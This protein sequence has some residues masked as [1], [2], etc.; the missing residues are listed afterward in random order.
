MM[1]RVLMRDI[2]TQEQLAEALEH[3]KGFVFGSK[4]YLHKTYGLHVS[5]ATI[6]SLVRKY[7]AL[8]ELVK[9]ERNSLL[10]T[11]MRKSRVIL[12]H[13]LD[14]LDSTGNHV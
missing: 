14:H 11:C 7:P 12:V 5:S 1:D 2:P 6:L 13:N 8:E 9:G 10:E 3:S 4:S